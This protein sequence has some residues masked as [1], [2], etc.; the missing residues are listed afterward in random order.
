MKD[1]QSSQPQIMWDERVSS[2][3]LRMCVTDDP[4]PPRCDLVTPGLSLCTGTD[5]VIHLDPPV[6]SKHRPTPIWL[7]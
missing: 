3:A 5:A 6:V 2:P 4:V 1:W 7:F